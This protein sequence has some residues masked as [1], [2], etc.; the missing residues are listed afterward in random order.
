MRP[1]KLHEPNRPRSTLASEPLRPLLRELIGQASP[2]AIDKMHVLCER[3]G[4]SRASRLDP[5]ALRRE[6]GLTSGQAERIAAAFGLGRAVERAR[7]SRAEPLSTPVQVARLMVPE[8]RGLERETFHVLL[9]DTKHRLLDRTRV[10]EGTLTSSLVHPR[11]FFR[12]AIR[13]GAAAVVAVHNHPSGD[14]E[15]S[16]E[17][18]AVTRRLVEAGR[19]IGIPVLDHVVVADEGWVSLRQR[20]DFGG[21]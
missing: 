7:R 16:S 9:L 3:W 10:S 8:L 14:P 2:N 17:D 18:E 6:A 12:P 15:P 20:I 4:L 1:T 11:E 13:L 5:I 21:S 19:L